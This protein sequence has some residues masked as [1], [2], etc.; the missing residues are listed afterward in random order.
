[1]WPNHVAGSA[2]DATAVKVFARLANEPTAEKNGEF[3][4]GAPWSATGIT[5]E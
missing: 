5:V 4:S 2:C 3:L 1:M